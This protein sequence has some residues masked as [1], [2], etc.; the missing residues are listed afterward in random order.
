M[1]DRQVQ[2][3]IRDQL[4][5][6]AVRE[7]E[8]RPRPRRRWRLRVAGVLVLGGLGVAAGAQGTGLL[9]EGKALDRP[10]PG[11]LEGPEVRATDGPRLTITA[12]SPD[13]RYTF[14]VG[15]FT[16]RTGQDCVLAGYALGER[17]GLLRDG[18]FHPYG[19]D[20][21]GMCVDLKRLPRTLDLMQV[22]GKTLV[23]GLARASHTPPPPLLYD[24][25]RYEPKLG[26]DGSFLFVIDARVDINR[27]REVG[28]PAADG[29]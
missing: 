25:K 20:V 22:G 26:A 24:G 16:S 5:A 27:L 4:V 28:S 3:A 17:L 11:V 15:V 1:S 8:T 19:D 2:N 13:P 6:A 21:P 23:F 9:S 7:H 12:P 10:F 29:G 14:G 18:R